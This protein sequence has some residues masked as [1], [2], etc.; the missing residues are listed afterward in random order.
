MGILIAAVII[1]ALIFYAIKD[2]LSDRDFSSWINMALTS[3]ILFTVILS[4]FMILNKRDPKDQTAKPVE[5]PAA[6]QQQNI[7]QKPVEQMSDSDIMLAIAEEYTM[8][9]DKYKIEYPS[10]PNPSK[11]AADFIIGKYQ[12]SPEE[13]NSFLEEAAK[14]DLFTKA[15]AKRSGS[16]LDYLIAK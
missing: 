4:I 10:E 2:L 14:N 3:L 16:D 6:T 1:L 5:K 8:M 12:F 11:M 7:P 9:E 13:W 15:R